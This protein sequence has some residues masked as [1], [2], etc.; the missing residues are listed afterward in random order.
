ME[1]FCTDLNQEANLGKIDPVIGRE[2]EI[3]RLTQILARRN[4]N[5]PIIVGEAG[6]G[7]T[8]IAEGLA[9]LIVQKD[10]PIF[11]KDKIIYSLDLGSL[12]AGTMYRGEFESRFKKIIE[13]VKTKGNIILFIDEIHTIIGAGTAGTQTGS[14]DAAN[15][16]KP[17]LARGELHCIGATTFKEFE[18]SFSNDAAL[19]R[20]F[21]KIIVNEPSEEETLKILKGIASNYLNFHQV[22]TTDKVLKTI[23]ELS[24][25]YL[26]EKKQPDKSIDLLD[27]A[28]AQKSSLKNPSIY[29]KKLE[30]LKQEIE[31][32]ELK[33]HSLIKKEDLKKALVSK[34]NLKKLKIKIKS[35][36]NEKQNLPKITENDIAKIIEQ[37]TGIPTQ[38]LISQEKQKLLRLGKELEKYIIGQNQALD[39]IVET[40]QRSKAGIK[41]KHKPLGSF[42]LVGPS[43]VGKTELA[44]VLAKNLYEKQSALIKVDMFRIFRTI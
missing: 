22:T 4:K 32:E 5:N 36:Q 20:R 37:I 15:I 17:A 38:K 14:L 7:K 10:V 33:I 19:E 44:K 16:L 21:Q 6:V 23:I 28:A 8:A 2:K 11:L 31:K 24:S 34:E 12:V 9:L 41:K 13:E 35:F 42:L 1:Y 26:A 3:E 29:Q 27:E 18:K 25:R 43:G 39:K 40:I 30:K